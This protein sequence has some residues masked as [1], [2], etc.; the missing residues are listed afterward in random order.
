[1]DNTRYAYSY[2]YEPY[3]RAYAMQNM[4]II[5]SWGQFIRSQHQPQ[6][7]DAYRDAWDSLWQEV[8]DRHTLLRP[9]NVS[10]QQLLRAK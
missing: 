9:A 3:A 7:S 2:L 8:Y 5:R 1:M 4:S 10:G 6:L